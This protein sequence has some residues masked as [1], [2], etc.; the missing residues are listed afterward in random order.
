MN[1]NV[2][3]DETVASSSV[4]SA[5]LDLLDQDIAAHPERLQPITATWHGALSRSNRS[6]RPRVTL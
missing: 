3:D 1:K 5:I 2:N 4:E 6:I